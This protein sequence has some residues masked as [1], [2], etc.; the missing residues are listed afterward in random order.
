MLLRPLAWFSATLF[1][2]VASAASAT[3]V[4]YDYVFGNA[5]VTLIQEVPGGPVLGSDIA[6]L[7]G[8]FATFD[9]AVPALTDFE[10]IIDDNSVILGPLGSIDVYLVASA[11]SGFSAPATPVGVDIYTWSGGAVDV[12]GSLAFTGGLLD[13]QTVPV[14]ISLASVDGGFR[15]TVFGTETFGIAN[16]FTIYSFSIDGVDYRVRVNVAFKGVPEVPEPSM[17]ALV[18]LALAGIAFHRR[19]T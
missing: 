7:T 18:A 13:G 16:A 1:L 9:T 6:T 10:F 5:S 12:T 4:R 3:P 11:A 2:L 17:A 15:T 8:T 14:A 19:S